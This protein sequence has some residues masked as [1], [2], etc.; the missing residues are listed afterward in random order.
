MCLLCWSF[1]WIAPC[2]TVLTQICPLHLHSLLAARYGSGSGHRHVSHRRCAARRLAWG[3][4]VL[5]RCI[6][7][8]VDTTRYFVDKRLPLSPLTARTALPPQARADL[9]SIPSFLS[10]FPL[11]SLS[12][13]SLSLALPSLLLCFSASVSQRLWQCVILPRWPPRRH[14]GSHHQR[15]FANDCKFKR[16][17]MQVRGSGEDRAGRRD[18]MRRLLMWW[19]RVLQLLPQALTDCNNGMEGPRLGDTGLQ[20][21]QVLLRFAVASMSHEP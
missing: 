14:P 4:Q 12:L 15:F 18:G 13:M 19:Q 7:A 3:R 10:P 8:T 16:A 6:S 2:V 21:A 9:K 17:A 1:A 5:S 11:L 20:L